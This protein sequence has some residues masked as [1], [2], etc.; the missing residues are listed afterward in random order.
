MSDALID[1]LIGRGVASRGQ[2]EEAKRRVDVAGGRLFERLVEVGC[3][4]DRILT[5]LSGATG[6]PAAPRSALARPVVPVGLGVAPARWLELGAVPF[7][8]DDEGHVLVAVSEPDDQGGLEALDLPDFLVH[9]AAPE[10]VR[11]SLRRAFPELAAPPGTLLGGATALPLD[12]SRL[13]PG[14]ELPTT[15][16]PKLS[17]RE[18]GDPF[19]LPPTSADAPEDPSGDDVLRRLVADLSAEGRGGRTL[20]NTLDLPHGAVSDDVSDDDDFDGPT[21]AVDPSGFLPFDKPSEPDPLAVQPTQMV[22]VQPPPEASAFDDDEPKTLAMSVGDIRAS[23]K[24][25]G[26]PTA[27]VTE[28]PLFPSQPAIDDEDDDD[29]FEPKTVA[30]TIDEMRASLKAQGVAGAPATLDDAPPRAGQTVEG[31]ARERAPPRG[32]RASFDYSAA[33]DEFDDGEG[34]E[35]ATA[36]HTREGER[37]AD[38]SLLFSE[39]DE[40][41]AEDVLFIDES[42]AQLP[43]LD[44]PPPRAAATLDVASFAP[45]ETDDFDEKTIA[46]E[47]LSL[48]ALPGPAMDIPSAVANAPT[49]DDLEPASSDPG[50]AAVVDD[51][52][53]LFLEDGDEEGTEV[54]APAPAPDAS[55]REER[56]LAAARTRMQAALDDAFADDA[57]SGR[58]DVFSSAERSRPSFAMSSA[59]TS[60]APAG[61]LDDDVSLEDVSLEDVSLADVSLEDVSLED[62]DDATQAG[63]DPGGQTRVS[64]SGL[65]LHERDQ[66]ASVPTAAIPMLRKAA[67]AA[68]ASP[69]PGKS[70][71]TGP[72]GPIA[73]PGY[74]VLDVLGA[75]GMA[76]VYRARQRSA[77]REVALKILSP[78]LSNDEA[79]VAR[80][81]REIRSSASLTHPNI[82]RVFDYG[83]QAGVYHMATEVMDGGSLRD[84]LHDF[85]ALP[86]PLTIKLMEHLLLGIGHAHKRGMVHRDI[87]PA[88]LMLSSEGLLKVG[89]F[90]I[91]KSETDENL[92]RTGALF[93]TPAYMSPEQA[94]G[95]TVDAKSDLFSCGIIG[96]ELLSGTNPFQSETA[97]AAL[98]KVSRADAPPVQLSCPAAPP[99]LVDVLQRLLRREPGERPESAEDAVEGLRPLID[100]V[101]RRWPDLVKRY[102]T[103]P[104]ETIDE[105]LRD[106]ARAELDRARHHLGQ[107]PPLTFAGAHA[108]YLATVLDPDNAE[109]RELLAELCADGDFHFGASTD[110]RLHDAERSYEDDPR[111]PGL[112]RRISDLYRAGGNPF[113]ASVWLR[114]YLL[115]KPTDTHAQHQLTHLTGPSLLAGFDE[116]EPPAA[117]LDWSDLASPG[118]ESLGEDTQVPPS[119]PPPRAPS[120]PAEA[121]ADDLDLRPIGFLG[122]GAREPTPAG[123]PA[124]LPAGVRPALATHDP[125]EMLRAATA[126]ARGG[127][128]VLKNDPPGRAG[129]PSLSPA[130]GIPTPSGPVLQVPQQTFA[131]P[132]APGRPAAKTGLP[133]AAKLAMAAAA[134]LVALLVIVVVT[135]VALSG[136]DLDPLVREADPGE[137]VAS[138][139]RQRSLLT[140]ARERLAQG[141]SIRALQAATFAYDLDK[142]APQGAEALLL[143]GR[144]FAAIGDPASAKGDFLAV[145]SR[146]PEGN[147]LHLEAKQQL[148][149]LPK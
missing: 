36:V 8:T 120:P 58:G 52:D 59:A 61:A 89:D 101:D 96:Y 10:A 126:R 81:Q 87:K 25:R 145:M 83:D 12:G 92:T 6:I 131:L 112:L 140:F 143:R 90:G 49:G 3:S 122:G 42:T 108:A 7:G 16:L 98:L 125:S 5:T 26:V 119:A 149:E 142:G 27:P 94:L 57:P 141:D 70:A 20:S 71:D 138:A 9:L 133:R 80:F 56:A 78:H 135:V 55:E 130:E 22:P 139:Q 82:I 72:T 51:D 28:A 124:P 116:W 21:Q 114:Q 93:G 137:A 67:P 129:S 34:R 103:R 136:D 88:N 91:A 39:H 128:Q 77:E 46:A 47:G 62:D 66:L 86:V 24:A 95:R 53:L 14:D 35:L 84:A 104:R 18:A 127:F 76:T 68:P 118:G 106:H 69:P 75:G 44:A 73:V 144:A 115:V 99:L 1:E 54:R 19:E 40:I 31:A 147:L 13:P 29:E 74:D 148:K 15:A 63:I 65:G 79:F 102:V 105:L 60:A 100:A 85:G 4:A 45:V 111:A 97:S 109:A 43:Q 38:S 30:M 132:R 32:A 121:S 146:F 50:G 48:D 64:S 41:G 17:A 113:K 117:K 37:V 134:G 110:S 107:E 33:A 23:L 2:V 11:A 123:T